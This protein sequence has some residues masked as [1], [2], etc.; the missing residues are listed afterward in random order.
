MYKNYSKYEVFDDGR[1]YSYKS[2]K[3]LKPRKNNNGYYLFTLYDNNGKGKNYLVH[4]IIYEAI[5]GEIPDG[6]EINHKSERKDENFI[7]NLELVDRK[8]NCNYGSRNQ[9][10]GEKLRGRPN[11]KVAEKL[12]G[13]PNEKLSKQ[14]AAY[15]DG[16]LVMVFSS[17]NEAGRQ[18]F[19]QGTI[20]KCCNGKLPH[21]KGYQW[22]YVS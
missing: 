17:A 13:R 15:R 3:F 21:Y 9:R 18:G 1:V 6:Y 22:K 5:K 11:P 16:V 19:D 14:V 4:R 7:S 20:S 8:T 10:V 12:R 2:R